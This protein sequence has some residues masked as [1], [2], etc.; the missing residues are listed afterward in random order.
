M[1]LLEILL[2]IK[3]EDACPFNAMLLA[4]YKVVEMN[5][6]SARHVHHLQFLSITF[7]LHQLLFR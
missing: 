6:I 3:L 7:A 4:M 2:T 5:A 1:K